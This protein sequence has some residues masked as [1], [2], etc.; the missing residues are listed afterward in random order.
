VTHVHMIEKGVFALPWAILLY[1]KLVLCGGFSLD[2]LTVWD[3]SG[4]KPRHNKY[5]GDKW[6]EG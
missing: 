6:A 2:K 3:A 4:L 1:G 5:E